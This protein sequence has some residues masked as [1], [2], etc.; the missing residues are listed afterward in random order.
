MLATAVA[1]RIADIVD[2]KG[3]SDNAAYLDG[4]FWDVASFAKRRL[5][6][7]GDAG[8][9]PEHRGSHADGFVCFRRYRFFVASGG[10]APL[11]AS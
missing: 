3:G 5:R 10:I 4:G 1:T 2:S 8:K 6:S 9:W 7:A 11:N